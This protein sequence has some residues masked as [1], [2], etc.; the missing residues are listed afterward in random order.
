MDVH[1]FGV[2]CAMLTSFGVNCGGEWFDGRVSVTRLGRGAS[3]TENRQHGCIQS[4]ESYIEQRVCT[5]LTTSNVMA[6]GC[7]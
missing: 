4:C 7:V 3:T 5:T 6:V 2:Q 1:I